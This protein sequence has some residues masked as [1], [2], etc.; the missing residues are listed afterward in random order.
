MK[1][2][3]VAKAAFA[4]LSVLALSGETASA[5]DPGAEAYM[6]RVVSCVGPDA[7]MEIY[8]P[9]ALVRNPPL[10]LLRALAKPVI[11]YYTLDLTAANKGKPLEPV[12]VSMTSDGKTLIVDQYT[13]NLPRTRIPVT[14]GTVDFDQRFGTRA[15]C[16]AFQAQN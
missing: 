6:I 2:V 4:I 14:G 13:R 11:G 8:L 12:K 5:G 15:K 1:R 7:K 9:Q 10:L 3:A 16:A